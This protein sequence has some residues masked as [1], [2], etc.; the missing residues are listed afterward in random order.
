MTR[1]AGEGLLGDLKVGRGLNNASSM[2]RVEGKGPL[3]GGHCPS[4][5]LAVAKGCPCMG[6]PLHGGNQVWGTDE[7][8]GP[9]HE[10]S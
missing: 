2:G 7:W 6:V 9:G 5:G 1:R 3:G 4:K 8:V 10:R